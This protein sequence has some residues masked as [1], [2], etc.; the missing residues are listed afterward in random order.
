VFGAV[1]LVFVL[2]AAATAAAAAADD[3]RSAAKQ[4]RLRDADVLEFAPPRDVPP[5]EDALS[6]L[7]EHCKHD[8][9]GVRPLLT[10]LPPDADDKRAARFPTIALFARAYGTTLV[11]LTRVQARTDEGQDVVMQRTLVS[12]LL[13]GRRF[14]LTVYEDHTLGEAATRLMGFGA[15]MMLRPSVD[16]AGWRLRFEVLGSYD[17]QAGASAYLAV[18]GVLQAPP[19]PVAAGMRALAPSTPGP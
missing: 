17:F 5:A 3:G 2:V 11:S 19:L 6:R 7:I 4:L 8:A 14:S 16:V 13:A 10:L 15:R 9:V 18:T 1:S 12:D